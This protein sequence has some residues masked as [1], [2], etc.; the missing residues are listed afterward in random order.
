METF[1][2]G[3]K[4]VVLPGERTF[5]FRRADLTGKPT[6][7]AMARLDVKEFVETV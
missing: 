6:V 1:P 3:L 4:A 7:S 5:L 2:A